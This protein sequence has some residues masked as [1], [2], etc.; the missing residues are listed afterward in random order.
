MLVDLPEGW[1]PP[2]SPYLAARAAETGEPEPARIPQRIRM[3]VYRVNWHGFIRD[4]GTLVERTTPF[5]DDMR[6]HMQADDPGRGAFDQSDWSPD[7]GTCDDLDYVLAKYPAIEA[8]PR[9]FLISYFD[10]AWS[11]DSGFRPHKWG[12]HISARTDAD[13]FYP[14]HLKE[15]PPDTVLKVWHLVQ[16]SYTSQPPTPEAQHQPVAHD[17]HTFRGAC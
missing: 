12:G 1:L 4:L 3:G 17:V 7:Y 16:V 8:D 6:A 10:L 13:G 9:P 2:P 11:A 14:E 15:F 5:E